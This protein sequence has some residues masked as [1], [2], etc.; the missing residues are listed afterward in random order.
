MIAT[1]SYLQT[2]NSQSNATSCC[3][4]WDISS[5][6]MS[7]KSARFIGGIFVLKTSC[8]FGEN[9]I[10]YARCFKVGTIKDPS[11]LEEESLLTN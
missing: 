1:T 10:S 6:S 7:C 8:I 4:S 11:P 5:R 2:F 9:V 3:V